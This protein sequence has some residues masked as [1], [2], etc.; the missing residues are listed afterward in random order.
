[1]A[2]RVYCS[3]GESPMDQKGRGTLARSVTNPAGTTMN[4]PVLPISQRM[5]SSKIQYRAFPTG[6]IV[7]LGGGIAPSQPA[8]DVLGVHCALRQHD[9]YDPFFQLYPPAPLVQMLVV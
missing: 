2:E 9:S 5:S 3:A 1:M 4:S 8:P 6:T 7:G